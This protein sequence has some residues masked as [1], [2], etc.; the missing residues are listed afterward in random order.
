MVIVDPVEPVKPVKPPTLTYNDTTKTDLATIATHKIDQKSGAPTPSPTQGGVPI[1][2]S[3]AAVNRPGK[4]LPN[5]HPTPAEPPSPAQT[6]AKLKSSS[7][8][9]TPLEASANFC[10]GC[11]ATYV[12]GAQPITKHEAPPLA[13]MAPPPPGQSGVA[14]SAVPPVQPEVKL[15]DA[16]SRS[17]ASNFSCR[18]LWKLWHSKQFGWGILCKL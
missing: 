1:S 9:G 8:C 17:S 13:P 5:Q 4:V 2:V 16:S 18:L 3:L 15:P 7:S 10:I 11:G 6:A 12:V 14:Y